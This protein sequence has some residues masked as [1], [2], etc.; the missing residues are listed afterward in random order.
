M[1]L[2]KQS[3]VVRFGKLDQKRASKN[4]MLGTMEQAINVRQRELGRYS[5]RYGYTQINRTADSGTITTALAL[6][7]NAGSAVLQTT[8]SIYLRDTTNLTWRYKGAHS[9][10]M[11]GVRDLAWPTMGRNP[12]HVISGTQRWEFCKP[13]S[14]S[15]AIGAGN[16]WWRVVDTATG[17][18]VVAP[19]DTGVTGANLKAA[20]AASFVWLFYY[21]AGGGGL[22]VAKFNPASPSTAPVIT[23]FFPT[24]GGSS[25]D[26]FIPTGSSVI[27]AALVGSNIDG[28]GNDILI[29][30]LDTATG[31]PTATVGTYSESGTVSVCGWIHGSGGDGSI[32]LACKDGNDIELKQ[33]NESTLA[34]TA[35][36]TIATVANNH[37]LTGYL[38][39]S[40]KVIFATVHDTT[41]ENAFVTR[42]V[43]AGGVTSTTFARGS[44]VASHPF[45]VSSAWYV[46]TGHD[47]VKASST[48]PDN[49][50]RSYVVRDAS[51]TSYTNIRARALYGLGGDTWQHG[52]ARSGGVTTT[53]WDYGFH[54]QV[55]V[56][57]TT[58][59]VML[60]GQVGL[61]DTYNY[62]AYRQTFEF[63]T[64]L[65]SALSNV[66]E[67]E[68]IFPGGW[69]RRLVAES[70][71][72]ETVPMMFPTRI[73]GSATA[74]GSLAAGA[75][76][77]AAVYAVTD[78][79][80]QI[81]R[82]APAT[83]TVTTAG[84]DLTAT[85][86]IPYLR[87]L[88]DNTNVNVEIYATAKDGSVYFLAETI[89][90]DPTTD[91]VS[92]AYGSAPTVGEALYTGGGVLS[93]YPVPP[94]RA[95]FVWNDRQWLLGTEL[96]SEAWHSKQFTSGSTAEYAPPLKVTTY[97]GRGSLL[98]GGV[99][100]SDYAV[101]FKRDAVF[102]I[103]GQGQ[104]DTG[105]G[106][107][108]QVRRISWDG[109]CTNHASVVSYPGGLL[110]Q[111]L[112][113]LI[114]RVGTG[115]NVEDIGSDAQD[116][117]SATVLRAVHVAKYRE[118]RFHLSTGKILVLDYGNANENAPN[119]HW[120]LDESG[121][122]GAGIGSIV[123][124][125]L[126][127]FVDSTGVVWV[128]AAAQYFDGAS[129]AIL[130]KC[131][132]NTLQ[133]GDLGGEFRISR[134]KFLGEYHSA[135]TFRMAVAADGGNATNYDKTVSAGPEI[136]D[137]RPGGL[138]RVAAVD[139][140]IEQT[141]TDTGQ[142]FSFDG[143]LIE[144]MPK[145]R[146][147]RLNSGQRI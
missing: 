92:K 68:T 21:A 78:S 146:A 76:G 91:T 75:Y 2:A 133:L 118:V 117:A 18:Q 145:G 135:H 22:R 36:T 86:V 121:T 98:A 49:L 120:Y 128:E 48:I 111:G 50:Q 12:A 70:L 45:Q 110:F 5:K 33:I 84:G 143:L 127:Q 119:G 56:S 27:H 106:G 40:S 59:T 10:V 42:Y 81:S 90:N 29:R 30:Q 136:F 57:G 101:L 11:P 39:G 26:I 113:G 9:A 104:D 131:D 44:W 138:G 61:S 19:T 16:I 38:T 140:S 137:V 34:L 14:S 31:L 8:D 7:T 108:F 142:G 109:G 73:T 83:V 35:S 126:A 37:G 41:W 17:I 116:Y 13:S 32:W 85:I 1:A 6:G 15:S 80:G 96:E 122:W 105:G 114:Y 46:I 100:S 51:S 3:V 23:N 69:P 88:T 87:Q 53:D 112:D 115:L 79:R 124:N 60:N 77:F 97:G 67:A 130:P 28:S 141:G 139:V 71:L 43:A 132:L 58:A 123:L 65:G 25:F 64:T 63:N 129:T 4:T 107:A 66:D 55:S 89:P 72:T 62:G 47:D 52:N 74:G 147:R 102:A 94:F 134:I 95:A 24:S 125:D 20:T 93:N 103:T 144:A 99:L 54:A 82:S